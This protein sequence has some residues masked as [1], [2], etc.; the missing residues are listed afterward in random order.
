MGYLGAAAGTHGALKL[1]P[2]EHPRVMGWQA[3]CWLQPAWTLA[4]QQACCSGCAGLSDDGAA[5]GSR[6]L[7]AA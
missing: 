6:F 5:G 7:D 1:P 2:A 4:P 3:L